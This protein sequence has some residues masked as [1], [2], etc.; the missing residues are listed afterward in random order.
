MLLVKLVM[1]VVGKCCKKYRTVLLNILFKWGGWWQGFFVILNGN[2]NSKYQ[3]NQYNLITNMD[4]NY[5]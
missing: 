3:Y 2:F 4:K 5:Y 1:N